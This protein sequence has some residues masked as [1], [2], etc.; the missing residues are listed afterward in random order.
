MSSPK[1][2]YV[3]QFYLRKF[4]S[5]KT[6]K[7]SYIYRFDKMTQQINE[8]NVKDVAAERNFYDFLSDSGEKTSIDSSFNEIESKAQV[9]I[10]AIIESPKT[11]VL[12][13][14]KEILSVFFTLQKDR[15][16]VFQDINSQLHDGINQKIGTNDFLLSE[17]TDNDK[18]ESQAGYLTEI[19]PKF[20]PDLL[21][22][23][24][25][26]IL[27]KTDELFWTSDHPIFAHNSIF[28]GRIGFKSS[29]IE[30]YIPINPRIAVIIYDSNIYNRINN[31]IIAESQYVEFINSGQVINSRRFL[32]SSK[33]DFTLAQEMISANE[34]LSNPNRPRLIIQ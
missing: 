34:I 23:E 25:I 28:N 9:A 30:L 11:S 6:S 21:K 19:S 27:N 26:L 18:K 29:G 24:W 8:S 15:T 16:G 4:A 5:R 17:I 32:F 13:N 22:M 10:Q 20:I 31:E 2:H 12:F 14:Y 7:D 1:Q 3:P 33:N